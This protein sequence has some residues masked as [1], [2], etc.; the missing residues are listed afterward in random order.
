MTIADKLTLIAQNEYKV[1][2]AGSKVGAE[3]FGNRGYKIGNPII[4]DDS[5]TVPHEAIIDIGNLFTIY[6]S[7]AHYGLSVTP[8]DR[9]S[10][11]MRPTT[12]GSAKYAQFIFNIEPNT[13]M[14]VSSKWT[15]VECKNNKQ[16][17]L[18][19]DYSNNSLGGNIQASTYITGNLTDT[20]VMCSFN[21]GT[22]TKI[23][24]HFY[25]DTQTA[26]VLTTD[27]QA[28]ISNIKLTRDDVNI[29]GRTVKK[30]GK[31]LF[32]VGDETDYI[33]GYSTS[34]LSTNQENQT[35]SASAYSDATGFVISTKTKYTYGTYTAQASYSNGRTPR[36][37]VR[38]CDNDGN[39]MSNANISINGMTYNSFYK[40]WYADGNKLTFTVSSVAAYFFY[41]FV[42]L[43]DNKEQVTI[44][45][46]QLERG[47]LA[48]EYAKYN[49][50]TYT[51]DEH[52]SIKGVVL[53]GERTIFSA[54]EDVNIVCEYYKSPN[55]YDN[56]W[57]RVQ[58]NGVYVNYS[59]RFYG[60]SWSNATFKP[61]Y[62]IV[63]TGSAAYAFARTG[64]TQLESK[65]NECGV[66]LDTSGLTNADNLFGTSSLVTIPELDF[67]K[68]VT[69]TAGCFI[70]NKDLVTIRKLK[71]SDKTT[72]ATNMF[73]GCT[74]LQNIVFDGT[75]TKSGIDL[76]WSTKLSR[77]SIE[78]LVGVYAP[79]AVVSATLSTTAVNTAFETSAG[80]ADGST[81]EAW[82]AL[83]ATKPNLTISLV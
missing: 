2:E 61:K 14:T 39:P 66:V 17:I 9:T 40:G 64:I 8:I 11:T 7:G 48:T 52:G 56:F 62:D 70:N 42:A 73:S 20:L 19:F 75:I 57:D 44:S 15:S 72:I 50:E 55:E 63:F 6:T 80:A 12:D 13:D 25:A 59:Y 22:R 38:L 51:T 10:F 46:I 16:A 67:S 24:I 30:F 43:G 21:T 79:D 69:S 23:A 1:F 18:I 34:I 35:I 77:A 60:P 4:I 32:E 53:N 58:N 82:L 81:S 37:L 29:S 49:L 76:H 27:Y 3:H 65:L 54:A 47:S 26:G 71:M 31:N 36:F 68:V 78:S 5:H 33:K 74:A 28:T 83:L 41:G 45:N